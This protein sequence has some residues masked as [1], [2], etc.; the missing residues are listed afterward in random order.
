M[1]LYFDPGSQVEIWSG[2]HC[3]EFVFEVVD[4]KVHVFLELFVCLL[5][6]LSLLLI[7]LFYIDFLLLEVIELFFKLFALI[8][9]LRFS[10]G[11]KASSLFSHQSMPHSICNRAVVQALVGM[12][13]LPELVS[14]PD[15]QEASLS[16]VD[17]YLADYL[18]EALLEE[19]LSYRA[20]ADHA[21]A[22]DFQSLVKHVLQVK[23]IDFRCRCRR[24]VPN[25]QLAFFGELLG[26]QDGV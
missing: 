2:Q 8:G 15:Q 14:D 12:E 26:W 23:N 16:A 4:F 7:K 17:C 10:V 3:F 20:Y 6:L 11:S 21:G 24:N 1:K 22:A 25:P 18:V 5:Q 9:Q 13:L 19:R